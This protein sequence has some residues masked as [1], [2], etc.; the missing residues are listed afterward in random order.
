M[1]CPNCGSQNPDNTAF[2]TRCGVRLA[3]A[4]A[5]QPY[6][7]A[8]MFSRMQPQNAEL[9]ERVT[10]TLKKVL[11]SP[12]ALAAIIIFTA[13]VLASAAASVQDSMVTL[14][15]GRFLNYGSSYTAAYGIG[16]IFGRI[17]GVVPSLLIALGM[18]ITYASA[19]G[20][21]PRLQTGGLTLIKVIMTILLVF[22]CIAFAVIELVLLFLAVFST[23]SAS[24][25]TDY[26]EY[27]WPFASINFTATVLAAVFIILMF[28]FAAGFILAIVLCA[29]SIKTVNTI[30]RTAVTAMPSDKVSPFVAVM[31]IILGACLLMSVCTSAIGT[32]F[33]SADEVAAYSASAMAQMSYLTAVSEICDGVASILFGAFIFSYRKR[34]RG[35]MH[36]PVNMPPA[37]M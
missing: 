33:G 19:K 25:L 26:L 1:V 2:C 20:S 9:S 17:V 16:Y 11:S 12:L 35:L 22:I 13:T 4:G 24:E 32:F 15:T 3:P 30:K 29:K 5:G 10:A 21:A 14:S 31:L 36:A 34:M 37:G 18:W 7:P 6:A 28:V 23:V 8:P 27:A